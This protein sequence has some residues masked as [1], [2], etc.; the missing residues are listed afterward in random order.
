[1]AQ[2]T[3]N[4]IIPK[5]GVVNV[6]SRSKGL[7]RKLSNFWAVSFFFDGVECGSVEGAIQALKESDPDLQRSVCLLSGS[8][9]KAFGKI[10]KEELESSLTVYWKGE[11]MPFR[12]ERHRQLLE[13]IMRAKFEQSE[14]AR[15]ALIES[16]PYQLVHRGFPFRDLPMTSLP[17]KEFCEILTKIRT[18]LIAR[19]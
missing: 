12:E 5:D 1:V 14:E 8:E 4:K 15:A 9:A 2:T 10:K 7:Q 19:G 3:L 16:A 17:R 11:S 18:E 13:Q 6:Q